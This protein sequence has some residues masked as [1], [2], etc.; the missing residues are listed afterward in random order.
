MNR[1]LA[2]TLAI[3]L[4]SFIASQSTL[5]ANRPVPT[6]TCPTFPA[7]SWWHADVSKLPVHARSP[8]WLAHMQPTRTLHPDFGPSYGEQ[9]APYGIPLTVVTSAHP[10]VA[11]TFDI[12]PESDRIK[13]PLG[14]DTRV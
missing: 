8:Q 7:N 1:T 13:Y 9:P 2:A 6:T 5:A 10:K 12:A 4:A 11:V 14:S 3:T